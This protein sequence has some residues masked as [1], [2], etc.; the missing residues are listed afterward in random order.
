M[1]EFIVN[2]VILNKPSQS[3]FFVDNE[4]N[5]AGYINTA[6][7]EYRQTLT[8]NSPAG[9]FRSARQFPE[10]VTI[11]MLDDA[12]LSALA[13]KDMNALKQ[14][15]AYRTLDTL[16]QMNGRHISSIEV[17]TLFNKDGTLSR[18]FGI[19]AV[20]A[21][22]R[23]GAAII[24][25]PNYV[26]LL[27]QEI[28]SVLALGNELDGID[29]RGDDVDDVLDG[30]IRASR[31]D[32]QNWGEDVNHANLENTLDR[33][34]TRFERFAERMHAYTSNDIL[35][36]KNRF[37]IYSKEQW[38]EALRIE[39]PEVRLGRITDFVEGL[40]SANINRQIASNPNLAF[41][42]GPER[43]P[44]RV[45]PSIGPMDAENLAELPNYHYERVTRALSNDGPTLAL[46]ANAS[47]TNMDIAKRVEID[48]LLNRLEERLVI[49]ITPEYRTAIVKWWTSRNLNLPFK[50]ANGNWTQYGREMTDGAWK[51]QMLEESVE[52]LEKYGVDSVAKA[53][54]LI[55]LSLDS[56]E[57]EV[58][59]IV[60]AG[61]SMMTR[62][63]LRKFIID[64]ITQYAHDGSLM[65]DRSKLFH[66]IIDSVSL[67]IDSTRWPMLAKSVL[68][69]FEGGPLAG[70]YMPENMEVSS[71]K[72]DEL[73]RLIL[74]REERLKKQ[75]FLTQLKQLKQDV[76]YLRTRFNI[77]F[78]AEE[79][80]AILAG[81]PSERF[82]R[83][84]NF[85]YSVDV[86]NG[87]L[88]M[89]YQLTE[90][91]V[92][93]A[94]NNLMNGQL[95][96]FNIIQGYLE[97]YGK[98]LTG[99]EATYTKQVKEFTSEFFKD[100]SEVERTALQSEYFVTK[101]ITD[102]ERDT[103]I[104][105]YDK[106]MKSSGVARKRLIDL[107]SAIIS[108]QISSNSSISGI[109]DLFQINTQQGETFF[110]LFIKFKAAVQEQE[111]ISRGVRTSAAV[112]GS[113]VSWERWD[114]TRNNWVRMTD[115]EIQ[116]FILS[117]NNLDLDGLPYFKLNS[118]GGIVGRVSEIDRDAAWRLIQAKRAYEAKQKEAAIVKALGFPE[119]QTLDQIIDG[120]LQGD[121]SAKILAQSVEEAVKD[122]RA[123]KATAQAAE[124]VAKDASTAAGIAAKEALKHRIVMGLGITTTLYELFINNADR[125]STVKV[126]DAQLDLATRSKSAIKAFF[127]LEA[128]MK[129]ENPQK[130]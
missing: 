124:E 86:V 95:E 67:Y 68:P 72:V 122:L 43:I 15:L 42:T 115:N 78:P 49:K 117:N 33:P 41:L 70:A 125:P 17:V 119:G 127:E 108:T 4:R 128:R 27:Q 85:A 35:A 19:S 64:N 53:K 11:A 32:I 69:L 38:I 84:R 129:L 107:F 12:M 5:A 10:K 130:Y 60:E 98:Y 58:K 113:R 93:L 123:A 52:I 90:E 50:D 55:G 29:G 106:I 48:I 22:G 105:I 100:L 87:G 112:D 44:N 63:Q 77:N 23:E 47:P 9:R 111:S 79:L 37:V 24:P 76:E 104:F 118:S 101:R 126:W 97:F 1:D 82:T 121:R 74:V 39:F 40:V 3:I 92:M 6:I 75:K 80:N 8:L 109:T 66:E 110:S 45:D 14:S 94:I 20:M 91:Y 81:K 59:R 88:S 61:E 116:A 114:S 56:L 2:D 7:H 21:W 83:V 73:K 54:T 51:M 28:Q 99:A 13:H 103:L 57:L 25:Q 89:K 102:A 71:P 18:G 31:E 120:I 16:A 62:E 26:R 46:P 96:Q 34:R 30:V 36:R 65:F